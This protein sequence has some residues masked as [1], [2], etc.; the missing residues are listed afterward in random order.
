MRR[1]RSSPG[2]SECLDGGCARRP[3]Q[4]LKLPNDDLV[5][6][7]RTVRSGVIGRLVRLGPAVD[8]ILS[9]HAAPSAVS[10]TLGEAVALTALLG[11]ALK[12][13]GKLTLQ[14][15][16]DG[17]LDFLVVT[18]E[19]PGR[20]RALRTLRQEARRAEDDIDARRADR[21]RPPRH[22]HRS[23]A[24]RW[25]AI[26]ASS[27]STARRIGEAALTLFPPVRAAALVRAPRGGAPL[28]GGREGRAGTWQWRAG[29]LMIQHLARTGGTEAPA[30]DAD[31]APELE[32]GGRRLGAHAHPRRDRRG[33]RAA[34][35]DAAARP[36]ALSAVPRGRRA[37]VSR[38]AHRGLLPLLARACRRVPAHRSAPRS[39]PTCASPTARSA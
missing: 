29:G 27:R 28:H 7:F 5:L 30:E 12:I 11:T 2:A 13:D 10:Q 3:P 16:T 4:T 24:R 35:S 17:L 9:H 26:R 19:P 8:E 38:G 25:S 22:H 14:T 21:R 32:R 39:S 34:R 1:R 31:E 33:P 37:R 15:K 20:L 18:Y 23:R 36:A 6:P